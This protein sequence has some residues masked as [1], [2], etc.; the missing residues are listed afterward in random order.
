MRFSRFFIRFLLCYSY[1]FV[2]FLL[3]KTTRLL[4]P[5]FL[6]YPF[7]VVVSVA[8]IAGWIWIAKTYLGLTN[9]AR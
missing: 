6:L 3:L 5:E 1:L 4:F 2:G 7:N 9:M 8:F